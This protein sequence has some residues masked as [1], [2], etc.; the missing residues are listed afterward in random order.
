MR[1]VIV[2]SFKSFQITIPQVLK[3]A[4]LAEKIADQ[5]Q[6]LVKPNLTTN[7]PPPVTTP[8]AL[9][10]EVIKF[11]QKNSKAKI[12]I[13]E[14]SGGCE[15]QKAF[16]DLGYTDLAKKYHL[17]LI[18]LNRAPRVKKENPNAHKIKTAILPKIAF[19]SFIINLPV[20]K[21][22]SEA[23]MTAAK[24]NIF[25]FYLNQKYLTKTNNIWQVKKDRQFG[26]WNKSELHRFGVHQA[27]KDLNTYIKF[28]F[29]LVD[30]SVGQLQNEVHGV[31]CHPPIAKIIAG[32][33]SEK[34]DQVCAEILENLK[35]L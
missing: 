23:G 19:E 28:N 31:P 24:K 2:Q 14:G 10:D 5:K 25:G 4:N 6:I 1:Q 30:A 35:S 9:V 29:N 18:D 16:D 26:W 12:I 3:K 22:H 27:I 7:L 20:L 15:T 21:T 34:V 13:A 32:F 8:V 17:E 33:N 11:C